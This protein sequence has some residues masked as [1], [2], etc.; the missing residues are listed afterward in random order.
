MHP[1]NEQLNS[2]LT[3][4]TGLIAF[5][6]FAWLELD[7]C[8]RRRRVACG[9]QIIVYAHNSCD[10]VKRSKRPTDVPE[11]SEKFQ[12]FSKLLSYLW[13]Y[14]RTSSNCSAVRVSISRKFWF[15]V[16]NSIEILLRFYYTG[17]GSGSWDTKLLCL[18]YGERG[19]DFKMETYYLVLCSREGG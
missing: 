6:S 5:T 8:H 1:C 14:S 3:Y 16:F 13:G 18:Y 2:Y 7:T 19:V 17:G 4:P 10:C 12:I 15:Y 11:S 9:T